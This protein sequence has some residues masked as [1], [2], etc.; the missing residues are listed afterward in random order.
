MV[1]ALALHVAWGGE[2]A[3]RPA[4]GHIPLLI[5]NFCFVL[6]VGGPLLEEFGWRCHL[7]PA[8][9][10]N[11]DWRAAW[12]ALN[13]LAGS[14][15]FGWLFVRTQGSVL[16]TRVLH[17]SLDAWARML[18]IVPTAATGRPYA[19]VTGLLVLVASALL[20]TPDRKLA[21]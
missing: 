16:P 8:T 12:F 18:A 7:M 2:V 20:L 17:T 13:I 3:A 6:L 4:A 21:R 9:S 15:L 14:V 10:A 19:L 5:A 1:C 11:L